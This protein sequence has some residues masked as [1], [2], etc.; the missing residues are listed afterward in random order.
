M[1]EARHVD[2][3][4]AEIEVPH[5]G[6]LS[7]TLYRDDRVRVVLFAFDAG[8]ELS[9]HTASVPAIVEVVRG[10][11]RLTLDDETVDARPGSWTHMPADLP[12]AV[13]AEEPSVMLLTMLSGG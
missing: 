13:V 5:E 2:D 10:H 12:H 1:T 3:V 4:L 9:S 11:L 7:Q 6:T 8:Q